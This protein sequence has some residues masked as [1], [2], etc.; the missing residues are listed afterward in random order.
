MASRLAEELISELGL[1][2][3]RDKASQELS[4]GLRRRPLA[5]APIPAEAT[6]LRYYRSTEWTITTSDT[7]VGTDA[8][9]ALAA[10]GTSDQ[11]ISLTAPSETGTYYYGACVDAV[12]DES[13]RT[14]NR[15]ASVRVDVEPLP[16]AHW[17]R[18]LQ[19]EALQALVR[20]QSGTSA[21]GTQW[22]GV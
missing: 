6:T 19:I 15:S 14:D 1:G 9:G 2:E 21:S 4:G 11:L 7:E 10:A 22:D 17:E 18:Q 8:V 5:R 13:D 16:Q 3:H 20:A 12:T